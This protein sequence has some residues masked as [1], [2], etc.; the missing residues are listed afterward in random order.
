[1]QSRSQTAADPRL[2][3]QL[4]QPKATHD[5]RIQPESPQAAQAAQAAVRQPRHSNPR[6][7]QDSPGPE[8][9][10]QR[11]LRQRR[12][13]QATQSNPESPRQQ[14]QPK[15]FCVLRAFPLT[16]IRFVLELGDPNGAATGSN[17]SNSF[18]STELQPDQATQSEKTEQSLPNAQKIAKYLF[19]N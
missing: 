2:P 9:R 6:Q 1:M 7:P 11:Q 10:C 19:F 15:F 12:Q 17:V 8:H 18:S 5:N 16:F 4:R 3:R 14:R 13:P